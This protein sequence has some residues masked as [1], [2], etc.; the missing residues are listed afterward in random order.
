[1]KTTN[2]MKKVE[3]TGVKEAIKDY[4]EFNSGGRYDPHYGCMMLDRS[5][6]EVWTDEFYS[7]GHNSWKHYDDP[8]IVNLVRKVM[9]EMDELDESLDLY[10][11]KDV[12]KVAEIFCNE[13]AK[14]LAEDEK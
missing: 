3:I 9:D 14:K 13:W 1:M 12:K 10:S 8:A 2:E 4:E 11:V 6:G 5:T 7:L